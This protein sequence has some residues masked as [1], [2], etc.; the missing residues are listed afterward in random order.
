MNI[1]IPEKEKQIQA[2]SATTGRFKARLGRDEVPGEGMVKPKNWVRTLRVISLI[3]LE[4]E[5]EYR[6][7][8]AP[9]LKKTA[10][11]ELSQGF[12]AWGRNG[13]AN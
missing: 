5:Q 9:I 4:I 11:R 13:L 10:A 6:Y 7:T 2:G 8:E 12:A 1:P 3:F